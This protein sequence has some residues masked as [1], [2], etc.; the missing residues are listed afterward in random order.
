MKHQS[1]KLLCCIYILRNCT[2]SREL[3]ISCQLPLIINAKAN[4]CFKYNA[5]H[6]MLNSIIFTVIPPFTLMSTS[7]S[8]ML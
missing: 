2:L 7:K 3:K 8:L 5:F 1:S 6:L 4:N